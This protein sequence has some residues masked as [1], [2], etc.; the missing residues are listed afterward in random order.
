MRI[1]SNS[2]ERFFCSLE[3]KNCLKKKESGRENKAIESRIF[4]VVWCDTNV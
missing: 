1:S 2:P 3:N 4:L